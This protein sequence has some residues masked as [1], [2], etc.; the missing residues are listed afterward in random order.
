MW[1]KLIKYFVLHVVN[2]EPLY[3]QSETIAVFYFGMRCPF[4]K[5]EGVG[6]V[7]NLKGER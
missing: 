6:F 7:F 5:N 1:Q 4:I 3:V 2:I